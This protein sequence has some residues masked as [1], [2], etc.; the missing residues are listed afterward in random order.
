MNKHFQGILLSLTGASAI[1]SQHTIQSLW[2]G[3]GEIVRVG[4]AGSELKSVVLK[5]I[6]FPTDS[7]HPRGWNSDFAHRRK[8]RSY[9]VETHWYRDWSEQCTTACRVA[10]C[11][12]TTEVGDERVIVLEDL[13]AAGYAA[14]R[15][16]LDMAGVKTCLRWLAHFHAAFMGV[17]PDNLWQTGSYWHLA[18]RPDEFDAMANGELKQAAAEIDRR[19]NSCSFQTLVHGD[20]KVANFCFSADGNSVAAVD[21]QYIG[22]GCGMK[23]VAYFLGSCLTNQQCEEWE[24]SLLTYY[25]SQLKS[26]LVETGKEVDWQ[27]LEAEWS[28]MYAIAWTDFY[29]FLMG[30][31]PTHHKINPY[32]ERLAATVI[33][34]LA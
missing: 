20:A 1:T 12:G 9:D 25:F 13:D 2:S 18:T 24:Q 28:A 23:D 7:D 10:Q 14:R 21:F 5:Y 26:A 16:S 17:T 8:V 22:G 30:W 6:A 34:S 31:M 33:K 27:A 11:Y 4:L 19:L 3:Y 29:R 32:T 15:S